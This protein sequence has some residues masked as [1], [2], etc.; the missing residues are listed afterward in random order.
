M[1]QMQSD[2]AYIVIDDT[3]PRRVQPLW[4]EPI[5]LL[6]Q[7]VFW[8]NGKKTRVALVSN[9]QFHQTCWD[10]DTCLRLDMYSHHKSQRVQQNWSLNTSHSQKTIIID[11]MLSYLKKSKEKGKHSRLLWTKKRKKR[12]GLITGYLVGYRTRMSQLTSCQTKDIGSR[13][14][15]SAR[16]ALLPINRLNIFLMLL[17]YLTPTKLALQFIRY[18]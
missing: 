7:L 18:S 13:W 2:V 4:L 15:E 14:T 10:T 3:T 12:E 8:L 16:L 9:N 5:Y 11:K 6:N 17:Y 1:L